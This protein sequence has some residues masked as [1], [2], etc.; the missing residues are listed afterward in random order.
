MKT[1]RDLPNELFV[2]AKKRAADKRRPL[3]DLAANGLRAHT[4]RPR[5]STF[6]PR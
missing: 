1:T 2:A 5:Q 3:R 4:Q 6:Q